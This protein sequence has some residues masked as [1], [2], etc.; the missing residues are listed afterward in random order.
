MFGSAVALKTT[1]LAGCVRLLSA[2]ACRP[3]VVAE[4]G[5]SESDLD[6]FPPPPAAAAPADSA[7]VSDTTPGE[8]PAAASG[9]DSSGG[10]Y[11]FGAE[12]D[13]LIE[14]SPTLTANL[15]AADERNITIVFADRSEADRANDI[16]RID[17][18]KAGDPAAL[19]ATLAHETG[20]ALYELDPEVPM[21]GLTQSEY[22]SENLDRHMKD[23]GEA[24]IV[25]IQ[26]RQE[27]LTASAASEHTVEIPVLGKHGRKYI[28][29][30]EEHPA[31]GD[32]DRLRTKI[33]ALFRGGERPGSTP[34]QTYGE[35]YRAYYAERWDKAH[36]VG[37]G[38]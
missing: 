2:D 30:Y 33:G 11:G 18:S 13:R 8:P 10:K 16:I 5:G 9:Q 15:Q 27:I 23:E 20:H 19:V 22:I 3:G 32:R 31:P 12:V 24:T 6:D 36:A 28:K 35:R 17:R 26:V 4:S 1:E 21:E 25:N 37:G 7:S 34:E 14:M 38:P 29:L